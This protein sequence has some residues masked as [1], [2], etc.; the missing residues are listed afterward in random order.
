[1]VEP[2]TPSLYSLNVRAVPPPHQLAHLCSGPWLRPWLLLLVLSPTTPHSAKPVCLLPIRLRLE[3]GIGD[4]ETATRSKN[5]RFPP[6]ESR[7]PCTHIAGLFNRGGRWVAGRREEGG[8]VWQ[9]WTDPENR[10][11]SVT[12]CHRTENCYFSGFI[13]RRRAASSSSGFGSR[14]HI[15]APSRRPQSTA[16]LRLYLWP[17]SFIPSPCKSTPL[18][19]IAASKVHK[20]LLIIPILQKHEICKMIK[21]LNKT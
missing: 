21:L 6:S 1:M 10:A 11:S 18:L 20:K 12:T 7:H 8:G 5:N 4:V 15:T 19:F 2:P 13:G 9:P 16:R 17:H 14:K 3:R